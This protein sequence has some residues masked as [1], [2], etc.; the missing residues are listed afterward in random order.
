MDL[1]EIKWVLKFIEQEE[2]EK[3]VDELNKKKEK[4][5]FNKE[6]KKNSKESNITNTGRCFSKNKRYS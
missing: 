1:N 3:L 2:Y 5:L 4:I 6:K